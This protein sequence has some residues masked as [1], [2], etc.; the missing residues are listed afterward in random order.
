MYA[1]CDCLEPL[2]KSY[3]C[4]GS[5]LTSILS[6]LRLHPVCTSLIVFR[7]LR[8]KGNPDDFQFIA[9]LNAKQIKALLR[10]YSSTVSR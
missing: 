10:S 7:D 2:S 4:R 3:Y 1:V 5:Y 9:L 6:F 8:S